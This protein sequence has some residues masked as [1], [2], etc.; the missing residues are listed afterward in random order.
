MRMI[1]IHRKFGIKPIHD[2]KWELGA[3]PLGLGNCIQYLKVEECRS[4]IRIL[5]I[6]S[7]RDQ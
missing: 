1:Y 7:A 6:F 4:M 5:G 2:Y 3:I